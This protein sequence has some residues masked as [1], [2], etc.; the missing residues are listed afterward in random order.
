MYNASIDTLLWATYR[1]KTSGNHF[2]AGPIDT[3][4]ESHFLNSNLL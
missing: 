3:Q 2:L 4:F 1:N